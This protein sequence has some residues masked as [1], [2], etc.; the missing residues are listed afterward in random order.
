MQIWYNKT[1]W[2]R[3][4]QNDLNRFLA[5]NRHFEG[6]IKIPME[7][8]TYGWIKVFGR[9]ERAYERH[10]ESNK[11]R[12]ANRCVPGASVCL[13]GLKSLIIFNANGWMD[14]QTDGQTY[15]ET[16]RSTYRRTDK[17]TPSW[18]CEDVSREK[19]YTTSYFFF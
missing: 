15:G 14:G 5:L 10:D 1:R 12:L 2:A 18:K 13:S 6:S 9:T 8:Q 11:H 19:V 3:G 7:T 4:N 17:Q 16:E